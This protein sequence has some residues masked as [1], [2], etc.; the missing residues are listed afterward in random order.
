[1]SRSDYE[2]P[3]DY[4]IFTIYKC[5][6]CGNEIEVC[7]YETATYCYCGGTFDRIGESYPADPNEWDEC[8]DDYYSSW[9]KKR[10]K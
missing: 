2:R 1:M 8:R 7:S 10:S 4:Q 6:S 9:H 3:A 5:L